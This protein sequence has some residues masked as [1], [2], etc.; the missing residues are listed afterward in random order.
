MHS[1]RERGRGNGFS[2]RYNAQ[3]NLWLIIRVQSFKSMNGAM[4]SNGLIENRAVCFHV[5]LVPTGEALP[6]KGS[7]VCLYVSTPAQR[8]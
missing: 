4:H 6:F 8:V 7:C 3:S 2:I 1:A 5:L